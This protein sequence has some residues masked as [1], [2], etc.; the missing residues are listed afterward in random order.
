MA[1]LLDFEKPLA[2]LEAKL[3]ELRRFE[4][5]DGTV[6][7]SQQIEALETRVE[8]LRTS[9]YRGLTRWQRVQI[10]RHPERPYTLDYIEALTE[11][12]VELKGDRLFADDPALVGGLTRFVG[13]RYGGADRSVVVLGHQK[14]RD[15]NQRKERRFGMPN[16]EGYRKALRLMETA[17]KFGRPVITFLD[18]PGAYPGLEAEERGQ[19]EA[20][21]RNLLVMARLPVPIVVVVI[22]EGASGGAL[23]IGVGDRILMLE[24]AWYSVISPESCSS[25]LW[26]NWDHKEDA[27]RALKLSATDLIEQ[28]IVDEVVPEPTGGAHRNT[29]A[30]FDAVGHAIAAALDALA[31]EPTDALLAARLAKFDAMGAFAEG[32]EA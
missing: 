9:I 20:I 23:G 17:A 15:T 19:A 28:G 1:H 3:Q 27:A 10:A 2:D 25:I 12:F 6:D 14:G 30:A 13:S 22:G 5:D 11:G 8:T 32:A 18:T 4:A 31:A 7:L 24:N 16:P 26:R 21:A 29:A